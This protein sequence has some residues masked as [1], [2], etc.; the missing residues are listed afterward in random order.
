MPI[1]EASIRARKIETG[2]HGDLGIVLHKTMRDALGDS[3]QGQWQGM[4]WILEN[5]ATKWYDSPS[6]MAVIDVLDGLPDHGQRCR[7]GLQHGSDPVVAE[8]PDQCEIDRV[9]HDPGSVPCDPVADSFASGRIDGQPQ[10]LAGKEALEIFDER[11]GIGIPIV[12][13]EAKAAIDDRL[14]RMGDLGIELS[15]VGHQARS[16][17]QQI[18]HRSGWRSFFV[19]QIRSLAG[20][21]LPQH[22]PKGIDVGPR[23]RPCPK[24]RD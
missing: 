6:G 7:I 24:D 20:Q 11:Q 18:A 21:Q 23:A 16:A 8:D 15:D 14:E 13:I 12:G 10:W 1:P 19:R 22:Q 9:A 2:V 3:Q 5:Q 4:G 17:V